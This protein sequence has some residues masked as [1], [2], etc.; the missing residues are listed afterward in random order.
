MK[1]FVLEAVEIVFD[2]DNLAQIIKIINIALGLYFLVRRYLNHLKNK[3]FHCVTT[4][5]MDVR[6]NARPE[7]LIGRW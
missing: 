5:A 2:M 1:K 3:F 4:M 6:D 7:R